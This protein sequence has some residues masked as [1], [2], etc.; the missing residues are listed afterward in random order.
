MLAVV[1]LTEL[2]TEQPDVDLHD[3]PVSGHS[4]NSGV[5]AHPRKGP[6]THLKGTDFA[7]VA[8]TLV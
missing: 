5:L 3:W 1:V 4:V 7:Q 6:W 2:N 8:G